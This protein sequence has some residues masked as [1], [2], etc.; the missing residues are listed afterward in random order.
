MD[1]L[2][3]LIIASVAFAIFIFF[4]TRTAKTIM[5]IGLLVFA[6]LILKTVGY[7]G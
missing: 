5:F 6:A 7:L 3:L 1:G 2:L 4:V